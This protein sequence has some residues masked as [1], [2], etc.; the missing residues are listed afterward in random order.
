M[1]RKV[2]RGGGRQAALTIE[3][4]GARG[5]GYARL[6]GELVYVPL[7]VPGDHASVRVTG[8]RAGGFKA[9]VVELLVAGA[10]RTEAPCPHF[11]PC[12]GCA[13]QHLT[14]AAY[15]AWKDGLIPRA[16]AQRGL[17]GARV[18]PTVR[19][20][21]GTRRRATLGAQRRGGRVMLGFHAR[22]SHSIVD[23]NTCLLLTPRLFAVV[24]R[25]REALPV[26]LADGETAAVTMT[27]TDAGPDLLIVSPRPPDL[28][29]REAL[30]A[31]ADA[32]DLA[33]L[34]WAESGA[35]GE[36]GEPEPVVVRRPPTVR[37]GAVP[38]VPPP[39]GFLQPSAEG[40]AAL[41]DRVL[42]Y[43]PEGAKV[44]ADLFCGCGTFTFPLSDRARVLAVD[45]TAEAIAALW[46]AARRADRAGPV[47]VEVRDLFRAPLLPDELAEMDAVV[48]DPPRVGAREQAAALAESDVPTIIA[49]SCNPN[50]FA[51]DADILVKG[52]YRLIEVTPV[53]QFPW[54]GHMELVALLRRE[55]GRQRGR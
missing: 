16:L 21:P 53:D 1:R 17:E 15:A 20:G 27:E 10:G 51:R 19:I 39:G 47:A 6:D 55:D 31:F 22:E 12:G 23:M 7:T 9:E 37:F 24:P 18:N 33:R 45:G 52:G 43:L 50:T 40:Q 5:D 2:R 54:S 32:A 38:V 41:V 28:A 11:G 35:R 14:D 46:S 48:F 36:A 49:V 26:L 4:L 8:R 30:V 44:V 42:T 34:S 29:G 3:G 13:A 25:L